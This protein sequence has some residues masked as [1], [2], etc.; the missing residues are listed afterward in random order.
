M[1]YHISVHISPYE[2]D[3][4]QTFIHQLRRNLNYT[5]GCDIIFTPML[6]LSPYFYNW[7]KST[8]SKDFFIDKFKSLNDIVSSKCNLFEFIN[9]EEKILGAFSYKTMFLKEFKNKVDAFIWFDSDMIFPDNTISSLISAYESVEDK[10]C[11]ITPQIHRLWDNTWEVLVNKDYM[12]GKASHANYF[13]FDSYSLFKIKDRDLSVIK[14]ENRFKFGA[15]WC[16]LLSSDLFKD[17][18]DFTYNLGHY[19]P[20]DTFIMLLLDH[21]KFNKNKNINQYIIKNLVITEN[22]K[23]SINPYD[24]LIEKNQ[25]IKSKKDFTNE[26]TTEINKVIN[27][28]YKQ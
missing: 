4:Y 8:L 6:N 15:G 25:N 12:G 21:Y 13:G 17:Y 11:I 26:V 9:E 14:N 5:E 3:N 27:K 16:N 7:D 18:I 23:Y 22:Y 20:D 2:I 28:V 10:H 19:G 24:T 1:K